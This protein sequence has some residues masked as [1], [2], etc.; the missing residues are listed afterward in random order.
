MARVPRNVK[1]RVIEALDDTRIVVVQG[2][3]QVGKTT[4]LREIVSERGGRLV[5]F[6]DELTRATAQADPVG[7]LD[8][9]PDGLL[10]IDEVQRVPELVLAL[11]LVVDRDP[12]PGRFLLT[13]SAN[14]LR[15]PAVEDSLAGRA[16]SIELHGF[17]QGELAGRQEHFVDRVLGGETFLGH[18]SGLHRSDYLERAVAGAYPEALA[19]PAG[20]RRSQWLEN[21]L[22][23]I[24]E[25]DAPDVSNLQRLGELPL[26]LRILAAR[27]GE[28]LNVARVASDTGIPASTL[29]PHLELLETLYLVQRVPAW[30]T[31]LSKRVVLRPK[32][33]LLDTGLAARLVNVSAA[34]AAPQV[35]GEVA[36]HL[37]EGF[38]AGELRRQLGWAERTARISHYRDRDGD[39]VDLIL[40]ADDGRVAAV[41]V[42]A[43]SSVGLRDAKW[44]LKLRDRLG[45]RFVAG[46][47]LHTGGTSGPFG[48]R[49][50]AVPMDVLWTA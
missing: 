32:I 11:K 28:E 50:S 22:A 45:D 6:D 13:G 2:A 34:G 27:D 42:K 8:Q 44:L 15:L 33:A 20:R 24:V 37:L 39:E 10:A 35:N 4:L 46:V 36:G 26:I 1:T 47:V 19:R 7:F 40:E 17:S 14:L 38:V 21:Y 48:D 18:E 5:T 49:V 12:H 31:N 30:S 9:L 25:R 43:A 3:R 16:E 41:E 29:V 23:R